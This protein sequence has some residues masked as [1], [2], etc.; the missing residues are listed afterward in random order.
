VAAS[1]MR[2]TQDRM[3]ATRPYAEKIAKIIKHLHSSHQT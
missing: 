2:K 3:R 1:K